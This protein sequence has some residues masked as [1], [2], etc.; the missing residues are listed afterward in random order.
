MKFKRIIEKD[1]FDALPSHYQE[2]YEEKDGKFTFTALALTENEQALATARTDAG[3]YRTAN[4]ALT[5][6]LEAFKGLDAAKVSSELAELEALRAEKEAGGTKD[7]AKFEA[8]VEARVKVVTA[9]LQS[10]ITELTKTSETL[11]RENGEHKSNGEKRTKHDAMREACVALNC[12]KDVYAGKF[13]T[14]LKWAE[15]NAMVTVDSSGKTTITDKETGLPLK[16]ALKHYQDEGMFTSWWG[17]SSGGGAG[18]TNP[19]QTPVGGNPWTKEN[20]N[21]TNQ[22]KIFAAD[23]NKAGM[24]AKAAGVAVDAPF[25]PAL[26][27]PTFNP[28]DV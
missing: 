8:A 16:E 26:G 19:G 10:K 24:L 9:P 21:V 20:W 28:F 22:N 14:A 1:A 25:H 15:E 13:P 5:A 17:S 6:Q 7:G 27:M 2:L 3:K 12:D 23:A 4:V 11:A 18:G